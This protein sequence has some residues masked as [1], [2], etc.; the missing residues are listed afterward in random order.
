[1][2][3]GKSRQRSLNNTLMED[4]FDRGKKSDNSNCMRR[5]TQVR[6]CFC[7]IRTRPMKKKTGKNSSAARTLLTSSEEKETHWPKQ[8]YSSMFFPVTALDRNY[9]LRRLSRRACRSSSMPGP[10][11][12]SSPLPPP[13]P[14]PPAR[15]AKNHSAGSMSRVSSIGE[16]LEA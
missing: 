11:A 4:G 6:H 14:P 12:S 1:M 15:P 5:H 8:N 13:P 2:A 3:A 9:D 7:R 10:G 16:A